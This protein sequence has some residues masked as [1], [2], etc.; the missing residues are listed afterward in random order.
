MHPLGMRPFPD[1]FIL[2]HKTSIQT[3]VKQVAHRTGINLADLLELKLVLFFE[4]HVANAFLL[5]EDLLEVWG[6][7]ELGLGNATAQAVVFALDLHLAQ[8]GEVVAGSEHGQAV[9][10]VGMENAFLTMLDFGQFLVQPAQL[11]LVVV[12]NQG[13]LLPLLKVHFHL[14]I[15]S[16]FLFL[17]LYQS[18]SSILVI[19]LRLHS[20]L[21]YL[22]LYHLIIPLI[23]HFFY[24][25]GL[26]SNLYL[27]NQYY[28]QVGI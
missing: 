13:A 28:E 21:L 16:L 26:S 7:L 24:S 5:F 18:S 27:T 9:L 1:Q 12:L 6:L 15:D 11:L 14:L 3:A 4:L 17:F 8:D 10:L 20:G 22:N 25:T 23:L 2:F 19:S